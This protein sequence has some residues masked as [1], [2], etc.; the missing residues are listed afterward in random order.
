MPAK[1]KKAGVHAK[2]GDVPG[3]EIYADAACTPVGKRSHRDPA[4]ADAVGKD[5]R[6]HTQITAQIEMA[7]KAMYAPII[8]AIAMAI[9][10]ETSPATRTSLPAMDTPE[11][12]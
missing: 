4:A 11:T 7:I 5:L 8:T 6:R 1:V 3:K 10:G 9:V 2:A 12:P